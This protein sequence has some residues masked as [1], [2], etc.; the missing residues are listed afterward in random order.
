[1][2]MCFTRGLK[3]FK[4]EQRRVLRRGY[5]E[6]S[7]HLVSLPEVRARMAS[8]AYCSENFGKA[9]EKPVYRCLLLPSAHCGVWFILKTKEVLDMGPALRVVKSSLELKCYAHET[10]R[11]SQILL[12]GETGRV[13]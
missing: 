12:S 10:L 11:N 2:H 13:N 8:S 5:L 9:V 1:M 6:A 3:V 7:C 4:V